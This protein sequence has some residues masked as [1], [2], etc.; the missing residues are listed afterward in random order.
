M[1]IGIVAVV[2]GIIGAW[3]YLRHAKT[4][5]FS[6]RLGKVNPSPWAK[7]SRSKLLRIILLAAAAFENCKARGSD[8]NLQK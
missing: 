1:A 4:G 7:R 2:I 3:V 8:E 6:S 5:T